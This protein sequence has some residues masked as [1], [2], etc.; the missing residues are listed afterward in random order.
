MDKDF[1]DYLYKLR[2]SGFSYPTKENTRQ[3][4]HL[5]RHRSGDTL[6]EL[7]FSKGVISG[8]QLN[9]EI[10]NL[11]DEAIVY[12]RNMLISV[13]VTMNMIASDHHV[14]H[15]TS[16]ALCDYFIL[17]AESI[18]STSDFEELT[19][20]LFDQFN[21]LFTRQAWRSYGRLPDQCIDFIHQ[22]LYSNLTVQDVADYVGY[23]PA[24]LTT[25]FKQK[26]GMTIYAY[27][28]DS[29]I[30]EAKR[31]LLCTTQPISAIASAL[32]YH[33]VSHFSKAFKSFVGI[34]PLQYRSTDPISKEIHV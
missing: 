33:S 21:E 16:N 24:Y 2:A 26:T 17:K 27:I 31:I 34:A 32:G 8:N 3:L 15:E 11:S 19:R 13:S 30:Q 1:Y 14:D 22:R 18:R 9:G 25:L 7:T 5:A 28:Q 6:Q 4:V 29:K 20:S 23:S 12:C 10:G